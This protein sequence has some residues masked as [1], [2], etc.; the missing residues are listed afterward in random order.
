MIEINLVPEH[1]RKK[2]NS[3]G[4]T[5]GDVKL[6]KETLIG[7]GGGV[8]ALLL[9]LH[10]LFQVFITTRFVQH[11]NYKSEL[12]KIMPEKIKVD[13]ILQEL[14]ALQAK[15]KNMDKITEG[16]NIV[17]SEKMQGISDNLTRG[18]WLNRIT[19]ENN[20]L[21]IH[22]SSVSKD[23]AEMINVHKFTSSL[24]E[25]EDFMKDF[26][27]IE[28]ELIKSR[29]INVTQTADFIIKADLKESVLK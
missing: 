12:D 23:K 28:L 20:A 11:R 15:A 16:S 14:K 24:K 6:P 26:S 21:F 13:K 10:I 7:L 27:N 19:L 3:Q 2:R 4:L 5:G 1:L 18:A 25:S 8:V 22:G 29:K 9:V 17:W